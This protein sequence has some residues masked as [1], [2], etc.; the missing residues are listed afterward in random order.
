M[1]QTIDWL[2][3][4]VQLLHIF[5]EQLGQHKWPSESLTHMAN[6]LEVQIGRTL[7]AAVNLMKAAEQAGK[8]E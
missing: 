8:E 5:Q 1:I 6:N 7:T 3:D 2:L 4:I